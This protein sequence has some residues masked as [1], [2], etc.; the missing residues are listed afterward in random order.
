MLYNELAKVYSGKEDFSKAKEYI[1][2]A[3]ALKSDFLDAQ[4]QK[5]LVHE[6][7]GDAQGAKKL[8]E[9]LILKYPADPELLF[10]LGRLYYN[11]KEGARAIL[12]FEE[13]LKLAPNNSNAHYALGVA[14][15]DTG[16]IKKAILEFERVLELNPGAQDVTK[17]LEKL[18]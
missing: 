9:G 8:L 13:A 3:I 17:R 1:E 5:A 15:E 16:E 2:K 10:Q 6:K 4:K 12:Q 18:R 14:Y 11:T 7:E